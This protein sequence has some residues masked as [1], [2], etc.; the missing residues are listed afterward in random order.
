MII[1]TE[2]MNDIMNGWDGTVLNEV[3]GNENLFEG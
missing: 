1:I 3:H 2:G